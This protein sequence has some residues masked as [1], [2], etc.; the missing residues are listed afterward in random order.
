M[1]VLFDNSGMSFSSGSHWKLVRKLTVL[2]LFQSTR[3][4]GFRSV[5]EEETKRFLLSVSTTQISSLTSGLAAL[6]WLD[7]QGNI[8]RMKAWRKRADMAIGQIMK[9]RRTAGRATGGAGRNE[10]ILDVLLSM[11]EDPNSE[12][13][14]TDT[15]VMALLMEMYAGGGETS[16]VATEWAMAE[17]IMNPSIMRRVQEEIDV[18]VG[19]DRLV[20]E[21]D[22]LDVPHLPLVRAT[23][24]ETLRLHL[25]APLLAPR[26]S[27][28]AYQINGYNI[29]AKSSAVINV[30]CIH[31]VEI[32]WSLLQCSAHT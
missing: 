21:E 14:L 19:K 3:I 18:Q 11:A 7:L 20:G 29:P 26:K 32:G 6:G 10:H 25:V 31:S 9:D 30:W 2:H 12:Y 5:R 16:S 15:T 22:R 17:M 27:G 13:A 1:H 24:K 4:D 23:M 28:E 8:K